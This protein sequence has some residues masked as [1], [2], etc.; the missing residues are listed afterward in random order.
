MTYESN[1][2]WSLTGRWRYYGKVSYIGNSE[3]AAENL[4]AQNYMDMNAVLMFGGKHDVTLGVNNVFDR[5]PPLVGSAVDI[6]GYYDPLGRFL[7][8]RLTLRW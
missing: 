1:G 7:F 2:S 6:Q 3:I 5:E 4:G 8:S